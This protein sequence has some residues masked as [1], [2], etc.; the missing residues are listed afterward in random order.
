MYSCPLL[1]MVQ[2]PTKTMALYLPHTESE[3]FESHSNLADTLCRRLYTLMNKYRMLINS[4]V[5]TMTV[6]SNVI[7]Y[8]ICIEIY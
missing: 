1:Y 7:K 4:W 5:K 6:F 2:C 3:A 8:K